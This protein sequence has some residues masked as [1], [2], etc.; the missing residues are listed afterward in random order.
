MV[1]AVPPFL[2]GFMQKDVTVVMIDSRSREHPDWV[3]IAVESVKKQ[4]VPV[5]LIIVDNRDNSKTIGTCWNEAVKQVKTPFTLFL[6]DDDWLA[7]DYIASL[8][9]YTKTHPEHIAYTSN[10]TVYNEDEKIL[11]PINRVCTGMWR[12]EYLLEHPFNTVLKSGIDREYIEKVVQHGNSYLV[13]NHN[14]GY[15]YRKHRFHSCAGDISFKT[16]PSDIYILASYP[17]FVEPI[18]QRL[19]NYAS[20]FST[21]KKFDAKLAEHAKLIWCEWADSRAVDVSHF[22]CDAK[23]ILR[24][25]AYEVFTDVIF[26]IDFDAFDAV[27]F[28]AE[29]IKDYLESR[30]QRSLNNAYVIPNGVDLSKLVISPKPDKPQIAYAGYISHKKGVDLLV[31]LAKHFPEYTFHVAGKFQEDDVGWYLS[32]RKP[33]NMIIYPWRYD[34]NTFFANKTHILNVSLREGCPVS[35]IEGMACG[36]KPLIYNWIG[37]EELFG[38]EAVWSNFAEFRAMLTESTEPEQYRSYVENNFDFEDIFCRYEQILGE[39][40]I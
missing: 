15:Y 6:G 8:L 35:V 22:K 4:T 26:H 2:L 11:A 10:M 38:K 20:V 13:V 14:Y 40:Q 1:N 18:K 19:K 28:V 9:S 31:A 36:L 30:L 29:H 16:E 25:H 5:D 27:I 33:N 3:N 17:T 24:V 12:T 37:S 39:L 34:I 7:Q 32:N 21:S 23:K